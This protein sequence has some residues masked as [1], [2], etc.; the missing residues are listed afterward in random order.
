[1]ATTEDDVRARI[2]TATSE[3]IERHG[4]RAAST[5][6]ISSAAAVQAPTIYRLFG[7]KQGLLDAVLSRGFEQYL[8]T[9]VPETDT[10]DP[11]D[12]LRCGWDNHID[13]ALAHPSLYSL[14]YSDHEPGVRSPAAAAAWELLAA[15]VHRIAGDGRLGIS[16]QHATRLVH[17]TGSGIAL[18]L[19]ASHPDERDL[20][21]SSIAREA[22]ITAITCEPTA[23]GAA[24]EA[25]PVIAAIALN[26]RLADFDIFTSAET[27]LLVEWLGRIIRADGRSR[28]QLS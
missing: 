16:E 17:A 5:R 10:D 21:L 12:D 4:P 19:I 13:F 20:A 27:S 11:I 24:R 14:M 25:V 7:D 3:L 18:T 8:A 15:L 28:Q 23:A 26:A 1:M 22:T 9:K 6:A 2:L